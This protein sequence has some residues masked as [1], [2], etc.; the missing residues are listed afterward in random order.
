MRKLFLS[1]V[2]LVSL[3]IFLV[4]KAEVDIRRD[5]VVEAVEKV[6]PAVVNISTL[7]RIIVRDQFE[8]FFGLYYGP[9]REAERKS[10]GSGVLVDED[11]YILTNSHVVQRATKIEVAIGTN[12]YP[13]R[14]IAVSPAIDVALIKIESRGAKFHPVKFARD[15]DVLLGETVIA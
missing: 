7:Q 12:F 11:G 9:E 6:K 1:S 5:F 15:D 2:A 14:L 13:A 4:A 10:L 8:S 3:S